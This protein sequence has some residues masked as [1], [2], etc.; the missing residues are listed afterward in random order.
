M[1]FFIVTHG[2]LRIMME[3]HFRSETP[4]YQLFA[5]T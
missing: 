3:Q 5:E 4:F 2:A 1:L